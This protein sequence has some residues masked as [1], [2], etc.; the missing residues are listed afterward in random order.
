MR[1]FLF[2]I[3]I[4]AVHINVFADQNTL[5]QQ[6]TSYCEVFSPSNW[7]K[8]RQEGLAFDEMQRKFTNQLSNAVSDESLYEAIHSTTKVGVDVD[9]MYSTLVENISAV[10]GS[11]FLCPDLKV[12]YEELAKYSK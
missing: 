12:Y 2:G 6:A 4:L 8:M 5:E 1:K 7:E 3:L 9:T 10:I 11:P